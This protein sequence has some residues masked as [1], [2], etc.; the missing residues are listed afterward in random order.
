MLVFT[1]FLN[2]MTCLVALFFTVDYLLFYRRCIV[3][4]FSQVY[5]RGL[6]VR[7][8][9]VPH[10]V[11]PAHKLSLRQIC[12]THTLPFLGLYRCIACNIINC[13]FFKLWIS[14]L[15][16][17]Y[18]VNFIFEVLKLCY[19]LFC[20]QINSKRSQRSF[21]LIYCNSTVPNILLITTNESLI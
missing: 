14:F 6:D 10:S 1:S 17:G 20:H 9:P 8:F 4:D 2:H 19:G 11:Q 5:K 16:C 13:L 21:F 3:D 12:K 15:Y 7:L 18:L